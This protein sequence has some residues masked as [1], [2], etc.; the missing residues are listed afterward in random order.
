MLIA[1]LRM[2]AA[3][4]IRKEYQ[5][6]SAEIHTLKIRHMVSHW[7]GRWTDR[8]TC[9]QNHAHPQIHHSH[10]HHPKTTHAYKK[11]TCASKQTL[12]ASEIHR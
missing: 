3:K 11:H 8:H 9:F 12:I 5:E 1:T 2:T 6:K 4:L 10:I 7:E